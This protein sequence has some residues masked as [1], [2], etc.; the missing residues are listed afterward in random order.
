MFR[1]VRLEFK[2]L[3]IEFIF[4]SKLLSLSKSSVF[5][6]N[7]SRGWGWVWWAQK[8]VTFEWPLTL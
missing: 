4:S 5:E 6:R 2:R 8:S 7:G 1:R 3:P